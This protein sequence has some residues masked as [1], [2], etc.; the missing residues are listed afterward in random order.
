ME[1]KTV[2]NLVLGTAL[3][4]GGGAYGKY[5]YDNPEARPSFGSSGRVEGSSVPVPT[6]DGTRPEAPS[7]TP[8]PVSQRRQ[9]QPR[10][11]GDVEVQTEQA[12]P[13]EEVIGRTVESDGSSF[14]ALSEYD[15]S[16]KKVVI[17]D[18]HVAGHIKNNF[19][20]FLGLTVDSTENIIFNGKH[21]TRV[22]LSK[23]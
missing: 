19:K 6:R 12:G 5:L 16:G 11:S 2:R 1:S 8:A 23:T 22:V 4:I 14:I 9:E 3:V 15:E 10:P 13:S 17:L 7:E 20:K 21:A 18:G